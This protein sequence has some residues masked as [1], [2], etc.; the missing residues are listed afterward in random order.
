VHVVPVAITTFARIGRNAFADAAGTLSV[1][2]AVSSA[3][4]TASAQ[5]AAWL[6]YTY[7]VGPNANGVLSAG[8]MV[9]ATLAE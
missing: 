2:A 1:T 5:A 9:R 7:R 4:I 3:K 8:V 6:M